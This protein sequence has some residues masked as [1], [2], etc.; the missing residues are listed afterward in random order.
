MARKPKFHLDLNFWTFIYVSV[1]W[2]FCMYSI[3]LQLDDLISEPNKFVF[4][5]SKIIGIL[6]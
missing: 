5:D 2:P 6:Q 3:Y 1:I 4:R